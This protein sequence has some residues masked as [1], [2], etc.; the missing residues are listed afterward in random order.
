MF[1][2]LYASLE[3]FSFTSL[4]VQFLYI[5]FHV[6]HIDVAVMIENV[7]FFDN[8][9]HEAFCFF[10]KTL[11]VIPIEVFK[12]VPFYATVYYAVYD[13]FFI[14]IAEYLTVNA[15]M[16]TKIIVRFIK[17]VSVIFT[18]PITPITNNKFRFSANILI[19]SE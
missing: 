19:Y 7:L 18:I 17:F 14:G 15:E 1:A 3:L 6:F 12:V 5:F 2:F 8:A 16:K 9:L 4:D 10:W 13:S 11:K